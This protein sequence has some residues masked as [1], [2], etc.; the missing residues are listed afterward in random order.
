MRKTWAAASRFFL[1]GFLSAMS[2]W[3]TVAAGATSRVAGR[4]YHL[5]RIALP[6]GR[7]VRVELL[8]V[9]RMD[10]PAETIVL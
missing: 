3:P 1:V 7:V 9:S 4:V 2:L 8:D 5:E 6:P 10:A